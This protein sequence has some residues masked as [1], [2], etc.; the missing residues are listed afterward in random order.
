MAGTSDVLTL[1]LRLIAQVLD[2]LPIAPCVK[3]FLVVLI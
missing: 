1:G 2:R 3:R